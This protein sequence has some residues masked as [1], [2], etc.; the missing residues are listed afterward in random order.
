MDFKNFSPEQL[1]ELHA[2]LDAELQV[3][4]APQLEDIKPGMQPEEIERIRRHL[5]SVRKGA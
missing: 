4:R 5:E 2:K 1:A 3:R